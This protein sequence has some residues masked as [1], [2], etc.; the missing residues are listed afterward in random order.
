MSD[1]HFT[2]ALVGR[3]NVGK[4]TL[5]NKITGKR[6]AITFDEPGVTRDLVALPV[7]YFGKKF[8][9]VDTGGFMIGGDEEDLLPKIRGQ[10]L[11]A[12]FESDMVLFLVDARDGLQPLDR[13]IAKMLRE[14]GKSFFLVANKVDTKVG[15]AGF[16]EFHE[17]GVDKVFTVSAEHGIGVDDLL[18]AI[19]TLVPEHST[20]ASDVDDLVPR[21]AVVGRPNVGKSTLINALAGSEQV[22]ASEIPG[23]TRDAID[24]SVEFGGNKFVFIDTAGIRAKR[25]TDSVLEKF[26]IIKSLESIKR[27]DLAV[28]MIDGPEAMSHQDRQVLRYVLDE[29]RAVVI[30]A[31]KSDMWPTEEAR[32]AGMKKIQ[33]GL[34]YATFASIVPISAQNKKGMGNLFRQIA[35]GAEN[36]SRRVPTGLLNR[37]AQTFLYTVPIPSKQGR[38]RAFYITQVST[39]PPT[40]AVFVKNRKGVPESFTRYLLNQIRERF[41]FEGSPVRIVYKER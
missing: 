26:S 41:G 40:F 34:E 38:N 39:K 13:E 23:T 31:N 6:R 33:E 17:I 7:E 28:L 9:L 35:L 1:T 37:M 2:V 22:I 3:P 25:K 14:R 15:A 19:A 27:C 4:S 30:A 12:I 18:D 36:F 32:K 10:V 16:R 21:I 8:D 5:F 24:V 11:R 29:D 20:S